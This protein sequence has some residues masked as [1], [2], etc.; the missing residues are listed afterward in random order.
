MMPNTIDPSQWLPVVLLY[1]DAN[2]E[3]WAVRRDKVTWADLMQAR[4]SH[5]IGCA[6]ARKRGWGRAYQQQ[7]RWLGRLKTVM[8]TFAPLMQDNAALIFTEACARMTRQ[9]LKVV[10]EL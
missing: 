7:H 2:R 1:T 10:K 5:R 3:L 4:E 9:S 6:R 8:E